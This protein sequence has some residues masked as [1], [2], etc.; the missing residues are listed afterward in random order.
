MVLSEVYQEERP[1][2]EADDP[3][4]PVVRRLLLSDDSCRPTTP[5]VRRLPLSDGAGDPGVGDDCREV[6]QG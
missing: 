6:G 5:V 2:V 3:T 1:N 4:T